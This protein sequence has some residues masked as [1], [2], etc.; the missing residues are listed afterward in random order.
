MG[1]SENIAKQLILNNIKFDNWIEVL[2]VHSAGYR[3]MNTN[4]I[5]TGRKQ[6][7]WNNAL[8]FK[9]TDSMGNSSRG[10]LLDVEVQKVSGSE[11]LVV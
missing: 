11:K 6:I 2:K 4:A 3:R 1:S 10:P 8:K 9:W 5:G 7:R